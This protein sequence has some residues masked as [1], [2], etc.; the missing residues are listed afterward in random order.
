[1]VA[2]NFQV[3]F[4]PQLVDLSKLHTV[5][6]N[7]KRHARPGEEVQLFCDMRSRRCRKVVSPDPICQSVHHIEI[8]VSDLI[9]ARIG[10]IMIEGI[11]LNHDE[12]EAFA[13]ADGFAPERLRGLS[14]FPLAD[15]ARE[16][17]GMF[18]RARHGFGRFEGVLIKWEPSA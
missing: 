17:M 4:E 1:M 7:R 14:P 10:S 8:H 3:M 12:I 5:R 6:A 15:T 13:R 9:H 2:Y 18:W 11:P 16:N